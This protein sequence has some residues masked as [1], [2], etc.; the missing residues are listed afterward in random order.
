MKH[1]KILKIAFSREESWEGEKLK[2]NS[3]VFET[4]SVLGFVFDSSC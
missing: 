2:A 1:E 3:F 4:Y